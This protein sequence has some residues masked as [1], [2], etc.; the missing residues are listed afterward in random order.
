MVVRAFLIGA[1]HCFL[2][3]L[4]LASRSMAHRDPSFAPL[5]HA[6]VIFTDFL[7]DDIMTKAERRKRVVEVCRPSS[8]AH[9]H[10]ISRPETVTLLLL[11]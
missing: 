5:V 11:T 7:G 1:L 10:I 8:L 4:G 6:I 9:P 3:H 2:T